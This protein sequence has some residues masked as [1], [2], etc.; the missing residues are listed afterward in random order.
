M[1]ELCVLGTMMVDGLDIHHFMNMTR[2]FGSFRHATRRFARFSIDR[3]RHGRGTRLV[4]GN[5]LIARLM[6]SAL[7]AGVTLWN[8]TP[9]RRLVKENGRI[10]GVI[11]EREGTE[12]LIRVRRGVVIGSGGFSHDEELKRKL[13]PYPE[14]HETICPETNSGDGIRMALDAGARLGGNTW[15][16]FLGTQVAIMRD[17]NGRVVSKIPFLRRDRNKPGFV[18]VNDRG[19]RFVSESWPYNDVAHAMNN[20][21]GAIPSFLICNHVRLWR[22]GLGLVRPGPAW[23]RSLEKYLSSGHLVRAK[24]ISKLADTLGIEA[25]GLEETVCKN[26]EYALTGKDLE[27]G[28]GDTAYDRWQGDPTRRRP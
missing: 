7:D 18:L 10:V 12:T 1:R 17:R 15:H 6:K 4:M 22:Y 11:V 25:A 27:F 23:A 13:I 5:A 28:K 26:N 20:N 8:H 21:P 2:S 24:T 3:V 16:N 19:K 14:H 9:A